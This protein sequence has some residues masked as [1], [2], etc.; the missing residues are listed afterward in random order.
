MV[1][2][3]TCLYV[4]FDAGC[5]AQIVLFIPGKQTFLSFLLFQED[6]RLKIWSIPRLFSWEDFCFVLCLFLLVCCR[7]IFV[8]L[9]FCYCGKRHEENSVRDERFLLAHRSGSL[10]PCA[11]SSIGLGLKQDWILWSHKRV[12]EGA[13]SSCWLW[14]KG[15]QEKGHGSDVLQGHHLRQD[16]PTCI[17]TVLG[18]EMGQQMKRIGGFQRFRDQVS[19]PTSSS[20]QL[21][22]QGLQCPLL[23]M[24]DMCPVI[25][26]YH[27]YTQMHSHQ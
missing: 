23:V 16:T 22:V 11:S 6:L 15:V 9:A 13:A 10:S 24:V 3:S 2:F 4:L 27:A 19:A 12:V 5:S 17:L 18:G 25:C 21:Q 20:S 14:T 1:T 7:F 26:R 8:T